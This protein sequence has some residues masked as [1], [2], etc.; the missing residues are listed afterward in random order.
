VDFEALLPDNWFLVV[1]PQ[2]QGHLKKCIK[3]MQAGATL[4]NIIVYLHTKEPAFSISSREYAMSAASR[5]H[6]ADHT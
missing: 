2:S 1:R 3:K 6:A 4:D 5:G